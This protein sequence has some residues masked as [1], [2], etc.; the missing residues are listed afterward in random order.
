MNLNFGNNKRKRGETPYSHH[1][2]QQQ[3]SSKNK[4][5]VKVS[6]EMLCRIFGFALSN[7][8]VTLCKDKKNTTIFEGDWY[9]AWFNEQGKEIFKPDIMNTET[10]R[11]QI[12]KFLIDASL[13][14]DLFKFFGYYIV[15]DIEKWCEE[16]EDEYENTLPFGIIPL[17]SSSMASYGSYYL[18]NDFPRSMEEKL[19]FECD[20]SEKNRVN[21]R[22]IFKVFNNGAKFT[23]IFNPTSGDSVYCNSDSMYDIKVLPTACDA[24]SFGNGSLD[25]EVMPISPFIDL[26]KQYSKLNEADDYQFDVAFMAARAPLVVAVKPLPE[27]KV[28]ALTEETYFASDDILGAYQTD[29]VQ[30]QKFAL[31]KAVQF[32]NQMKKLTNG[33]SVNLDDDDNLSLYDEGTRIRQ[34]KRQKY[35]RSDLIDAIHILPESMDVIH[36][37]Q[38][39][40]VIDVELLRR[41]FEISI[42]DVLKMPYQYIKSLS[43]GGLGGSSSSNQSK[44]NNSGGGVNESQ[45]SMHE[46]ILHK[47]VKRQQLTFN[48]IFSRIYAETYSILDNIAI[49]N[50]IHDVKKEKKKEVNDSDDDD[51]DTSKSETMQEEINDIKKHVIEAKIVFDTKLT[52]TTESFKI[53]LDSYKEGVIDGSV[54]RKKIQSINGM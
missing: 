9:M 29:N 33:G 36:A 21:S 44:S 1:Y 12:E 16:C 42:C 50:F 15:K 52:P 13:M 46:K 48:R 28:D 35:Q 39:Q 43:S 6:N 49:D 8:F 24:Y 54:V 2:Q 47:E 20:A 40:R 41:N 38:P 22:Y 34:Y 31:K 7:N 30:K 14:L 3:R 23:P 37:Y 11:L 27:T 25:S 32:S 18:I 5:K 45:F 53:L 19:V 4:N 17:Y 10:F 26:Y 51:N